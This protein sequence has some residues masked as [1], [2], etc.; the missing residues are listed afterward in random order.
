MDFIE[1]LFGISP[2]GREGTIELSI[3]LAL[4]AAIAIFALRR[5]SG[6]ADS[7]PGARLPGE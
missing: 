5:R 6:S 7:T 3:L 1:R 4:I 2:D